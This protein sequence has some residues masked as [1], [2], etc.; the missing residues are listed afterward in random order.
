MVDPIPTDPRPFRQRLD[1]LQS[2]FGGRFSRGGEAMVAAHMV[3]QAKMNGLDKRLNAL[4]SGPDHRYDGCRT[5]HR[6]KKRSRRK[7]SASNY[8]ISSS[9]GP[10][11]HW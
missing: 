3:S 5:R 7:R 8:Q 11:Y 6:H 10:S 4:L 2:Y 9:T 1:A